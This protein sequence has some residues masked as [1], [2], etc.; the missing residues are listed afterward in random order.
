[1]AQSAVVTA[2][3]PELPSID[4]FTPPVI[5][6]FPQGRPCV[7]SKFLFVE[8][9]KLYVRGVTYGTFRPDQDGNDYPPLSS[10]EQ[11]FR[12]MVSNGINAV[13]TYTVPP[14]WLLDAAHK[15]GLRVMVGLPWEQH[16]TFLDSKKVSD[17]IEERVRAGI[18]ACVG[19]PAILCYSI[20]NEIP[21]QIV[22]WYGRHRV[23][24]F[25]RRLYQAAKS[26]DP[27]GLVTYVNYPTTEYLQLP[28]LDLVC[29]NVYLEA[30]DR[31][32]AYLARLQ[33][34]AEDKPL[35]IAEIGMDSRRHGSEAQAQT[36]DW[37]IRTA[38]AGGC[39]GTFVFA[40]TDKW[41]R[42]GYDIEDWD[43]GLVD[44]NNQAKSALETVCKAFAESPFPS[45]QPWPFI[46]VILCSYNGSRT[47]RDCLEGLRK[48]EYPNFE[49]IVVDDG[50]TDGTASIVGEYGFRLISTSNHGLS[51][52]RNTGMRAAKGEIVAYIDDDAYP[53]P[54]WLTYLAATFNSTNYAGVGG[55]NIAPPEDGLIAKSV[56]NAPGGPVHVLVSD[57]E[58]EHIP[59]CNMAFRKPA[60]E[61]IDGFD[62]QFRTAGDDVDIC[63]RL[64]KQEMKLGFSPAALVWHHRRNSVRAYWKQQEGYGR[65]ESLLEKKWPE[66]YNEFG[67]LS[68]SGRVYDKALSYIFL[69]SRARI[70]Q[71]TWGCASFQSIYEPAAG[72]FWSLVLMP[73]WYLIIFVLGLLSTLSILWKPLLLALPLLAVA[74]S[75]PIVR[76]VKAAV[77]DT[78]PDKPGKTLDHLKYRSL[79]VLLYLMQPLARLSGRLRHG[80]SPWRFTLKYF[81]FAW[82]QTVSAWSEQW[83]STE[84]RLRHIEATLRA[85]GANVTRSGDYDHWDME[86]RGGLLGGSRILMAVEEHGGGKQLIRSRLW[87]RFSAR[88]TILVSMFASLSIWSAVDHAKVASSLLGA[89]ALLMA[90]RT[91][92]ECAATIGASLKALSMTDAGMQSEKLSELENGLGNQC[93]LN[94]EDQNSILNVEGCTKQGD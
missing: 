3:Y 55:P 59:G 1:M 25:I 84:E 8:D 29:F 53:D 23:E 68:W 44:R 94:S 34:I 73:E 33:N 79:I 87:P 42:G 28:F 12:C 7:K 67:H 37:Q 4:Q 83:K 14:H 66:K 9:K 91:L 50:S 35:I 65:A 20:G 71:G 85:I 75:L 86:V 16:V 43:F 39:A 54:Q 70:Y 6:T 81:S 30:R 63:W 47:I 90:M 40:W 18:R 41:H 56:A 74:V 36:L 76:A 48:L 11:D 82:P 17:S 93:K 46:S 15:F 51:S 45:D 58:A 69:W 92:F 88:A 38:F 2:R 21:S 26:E 5:T 72:M 64:Q 52:A 60:I 24:R 19:H 61:A 80:L 78:S 22:R 10:V 77:R 13:R 49:V 57:Q 89:I 27:D 62:H 32:E 31:F